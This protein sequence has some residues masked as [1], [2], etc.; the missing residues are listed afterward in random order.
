MKS[1]KLRI[2]VTEGNRTKVDL[3]FGARVTENLP[4]LI[5]DYLR[6]KLEQRAI[7]VS[8][9]AKDAVAGHFEV[10]ELFQLSEGGKTISVWLE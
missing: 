4:E 3:T 2:R 5:P 10:G 8:K 7:D 9:I 6:P 1:E